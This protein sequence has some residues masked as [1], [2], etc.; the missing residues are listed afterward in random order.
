MHIRVL[1]NP[2]GNDPELDPDRPADP[3]TKAIDKTAPRRG[4]RDGSDAPRPAQESSGN[5]VRAKQTTNANERC[6]FI[7]HSMTIEL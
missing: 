6:T 5:Q 2:T 4:K 7:D 3:P 1:I